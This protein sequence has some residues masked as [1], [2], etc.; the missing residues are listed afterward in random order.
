[1]SLSLTVARLHIVPKV[2]SHGTASIIGEGSALPENDPTFA[3]IELGSWKYAEFIEVPN[4]LIADTGVDL[5]G[6]LAKQGGYALGFGSDNHYV[7]GSGTNQPLGFL[8]TAGTAVTGATGGTGVPSIANLIDMAYSVDP[9]YQTSAGWLMRPSSAAYIRKLT[10][11]S[12]NPEQWAPSLQAGQPDNLLGFPVTTS[13][14]MPAYGTP[15]KPI[16]FGSW[17]TFIVRDV[18]HSP[19]GAVMRFERSDD[20][21]FNRDVVAFRAVMRTDSEQVDLNGLKL[22]CGPST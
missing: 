17:D 18:R 13:Q 2:A 19:G 20:Y 14:F 6:Y 22:F 12:A 8:A 21:A 3:T 5:L 1:M 9:I 7:N 4:E 10:A 16:A 15:A 11:A